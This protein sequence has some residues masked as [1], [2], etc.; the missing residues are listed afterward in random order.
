[1]TDYREPPQGSLQLYRNV[2]AGFVARGSSLAAW[3]RVNGVSRRNIFAKLP[4]FSGHDVAQAQVLR[5]RRSFAVKDNAEVYGA[6]SAEGV[7]GA[8]RHLVRRGLC[9]AGRNTGLGGASPFDR[10]TSWREPVRR[11]H[12]R[13]RAGRT[14]RGAR[15]R[16]LAHG[17]HEGSPEQPLL[18]RGRA[19]PAGGRART[20]ATRSSGL[21]PNSRPREDRLR[22][23]GRAFRRIT[24]SQ[25]GCHSRARDRRD[26]RRRSTGRNSPSASRR[27]PSLLFGAVGRRSAW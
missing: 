27:R 19:R 20:S 21:R 10:V 22:L 23:R 17:V 15:R 3:C 7:A 4:G 2:R 14:A 24:G 18:Y 8:L 25:S 16:R 1:M 6:G 5:A 12:V 9:A 26:R 11:I 13:A